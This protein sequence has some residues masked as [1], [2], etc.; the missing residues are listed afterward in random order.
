VDYGAV[1][2]RERAVLE[3]LGDHL[4]HREIGERLFISVRTVESHVASLRRKLDIADHR[5]L[6]RFAAAQQS[7]I[8]MPA[9]SAMPVPLTSFVG[10]STEMAELATALR[11]SRLVSAVGPG[12]AGKTRLAISTAHDV[13]SNY[14]DGIR[15]V[16]LVPVTDPA[17]LQAAVAQACG[18]TPSSRRSPVDAIISTLRPE[19]VLLVL[20]NCEHLVNAVAVL[21]ER[22]VSGCPTLTILVTSRARLAVPFE[23]VYRLTGLTSGREGD[24]VALFVDRA[25]AAGSPIPSPSELERITAVC[26]ALGGLALAVELAA[27]RLPSLGLDGVEHGLLKQ[28]DLLTGGTRINP[29]QRS[30]RET[31]DWSVTMLDESARA[32]L[33]RLSVLVGSFDIDV[34]TA[35]AAFAPMSAVDIRSAVIQLADH[36]LLT[37][38]AMV[39]GQLRYRLLEPI[40]QYGLARMTAQDLP[41]FGQHLRW[42]LR[43][44]DAFLRAGEIDVLPEL[45][46]DARAALRWAL[47]QEVPD[48]AAHAL[49]RSL[50]LLLFRTGHLAEAQLRMEQAAGLAGDPQEA[51]E[52]FGEAAAVAKCRVQGEDALRLELAA[53]DCHRRAGQQS[54]AALALARAA[55]LLT[56][57]SGMFA[58]TDESF[59]EQLLTEARSLAPLVHLISAA[60][61]VVAANSKALT[62]ESAGRGAAA[63]ARAREVQDKWLESAAMDAAT[64][65]LLRGGEVI[66]AHRLA[67]QRVAGLLPHQHDLAAGL[68]LKDALHNAVFCAL[69]AGD[70]PGARTMAGRQRGLSFLREQ[71]D[72]ADEELLAPAALAGDWATVFGTGE[73][74]L[75]DWAAAGRHAAPGR[76]LGPAAVALAYG[77]RADQAARD[78]WLGVL[79]EIRGVSRDDAGKGSGYGEVFDAMV[80][81]ENGQPDTALALLRAASGVGIFD[82]VFR[83]WSIALTAEAAV[84]AEDNDAEQC[85][86]RASVSSIGNP[87]ASA[88]TRRAAA[89]R[90]HDHQ[91]LRSVA[92]DFDGAG[93]TYQCARTRAL[94]DG[95]PGHL[96]F[97]LP[98]GELTLTPSH[99]RG[100]DQRPA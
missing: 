79:A 92:A 89:L 86:A 60:V 45:A 26:D 75:Q 19:E 41:A 87:I 32:T 99:V 82:L 39:H 71:H 73:R 5:E 10:R 83:Q 70:L 66:A 20:D 38:S 72:L 94:A 50:G 14:R 76:G 47:G 52:R 67:D 95:R 27:V 80:S 63:L 53:A 93:S 23:R 7:S 6:V 74:F 85:L 81:L 8:S 40:R 55:E 65:E 97:P 15:F 44:I 49:A 11:E 35:V 33:P 28:A 30:M 59:A 56:R 22:L 21:T 16:D 62:A 77:L 43:A 29:R 4:T 13:T 3:L 36:N 68:E 37:T 69:G 91:A 61:T 17:G 1:T 2:S 64:V 88:I 42:C 90:T 98:A 54:A 31:L 96:A 34:A 25:I 24:A 78:R 84:L 100:G 12:G 9:G 46:G 51:A 48:S 58:E 18:A 57:F